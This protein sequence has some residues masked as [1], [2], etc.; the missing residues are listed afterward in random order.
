ME[1]SLIKPIHGMSYLGWITADYHTATREFFDL[2][3]RFFLRRTDGVKVEVAY[4]EVSKLMDKEL[5]RITQSNEW[6][7]MEIKDCHVADFAVIDGKY[8]IFNISKNELDKQGHLIIDMGKTDS[9]G[10][11]LYG[12]FTFWLNVDFNLPMRRTGL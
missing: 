5:E 3:N 12:Y 6:L 2:F 10:D 4:F 11:D 1:K 7:V 9:E 8:F